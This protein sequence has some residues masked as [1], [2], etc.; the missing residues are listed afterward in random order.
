VLQTLSHQESLEP[1]EDDGIDVPIRLGFATFTFDVALK[2]SGDRIVVAECK[3]LSKP[4]RVKQG[5]IAEFAH[6]I[7]LLR[8]HKSSNVAGVFFT[9]TAY[10]DGAVKHASWEGISIA[11]CE[12]SESPNHIFLTYHM[13]DPVRDEQIRHHLDHRSIALSEDML[14]FRATASRGIAALPSSSALPRRAPRAGTRHWTRLRSS[15]VR[16]RA[17]SH[18][19]CSRVSAAIKFIRGIGSVGVDM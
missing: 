18:P 10:Q 19:P 2:G 16:R 15:D 9:K 14:M 11:V 7:E 17:C 13:Y 12:P 5:H 6:K 3:A 8:K 4:G 1:Y